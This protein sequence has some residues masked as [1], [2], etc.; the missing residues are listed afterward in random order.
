[1]D[2]AREI[3]GIPSLAAVFVIVTGI[4]GAC[5][6]DMIF[7]FIGVSDPRA[8]GVALGTVA[9]AVGTAKAVSDSTVAG[10]FAS[11]ALCVNGILTAIFLPLIFWLLNLYS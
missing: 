4:I 8:K 6:A 3:G 1:M 9:H 5:F 7:R 2:A 11:V 10:A